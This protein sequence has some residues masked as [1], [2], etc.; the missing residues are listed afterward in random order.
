MVASA[1]DD[2]TLRLRLD[3]PLGGVEADRAVRVVDQTGVTWGGRPASMSRVW[4]MPSS[5]A[6]VE[7]FVGDRRHFAFPFQPRCRR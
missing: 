2:P 5:A 7:I 4:R 6:G 1:T 3:T